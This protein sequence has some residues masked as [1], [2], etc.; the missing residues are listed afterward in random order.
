MFFRSKNQQLRLFHK[1]IHYKRRHV[2]AQS[3]SLQDHDYTAAPIKTEDECIELKE[4]DEDKD[5]D[6]YFMDTTQLGQSEIMVQRL[7]KLT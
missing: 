6:Y 2:S 3:D 4:Y 7:I 5:K 1:S